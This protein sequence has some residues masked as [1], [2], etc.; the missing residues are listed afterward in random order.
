MWVERLRF[1][2]L[3]S[4][5]SF[6]YFADLQ[7]KAKSLPHNI[8]RGPDMY[9]AQDA[10]SPFTLLWP[11]ISRTEGLLQCLPPREQL[12]R[13]LISS[14][15]KAQEFAFPYV[16]EELTRKEA[17]RF[18]EHVEENA[19]KM[20]DLLALVFAA[21]A[22][23]AQLETLRVDGEGRTILHRFET[24]RVRHL[25]SD[26]Y[27][28]NNYLLADA[29]SPSIKLYQSSHAEEHTSISHARICTSHSSGAVV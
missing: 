15:H 24:A 13:H 11:A 2:N 1:T 19:K 4:D 26:R 23:G 3:C 16:P 10:I 22:S 6:V 29:G 7:V 8:P 27:R 9:A 20:P 21:P 12:F 14:D 28:A 17:E 5:S 25:V 18:L